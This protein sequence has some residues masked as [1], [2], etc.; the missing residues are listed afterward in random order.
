MMIL[1]YNFLSSYLFFLGK[2]ISIYDIERTN[3]QFFGALC[4]GN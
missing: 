2:N 1:L 4:T 3:P